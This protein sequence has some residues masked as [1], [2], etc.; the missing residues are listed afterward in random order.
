MLKEHTH[1]RA[2]PTP[3]ASTLPD[4]FTHQPAVLRHGDAAGMHLE[5]HALADAGSK[6]IRFPGPLTLVPAGA[7]AT[8]TDPQAVRPLTPICWRL[9][10][11]LKV[12]E[13]ALLL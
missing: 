12:S 5:A 6:S 11:P 13:K 10:G 1:A 9:Q 2:G 8:D 7:P 3:H 4:E